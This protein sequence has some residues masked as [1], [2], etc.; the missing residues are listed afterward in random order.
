MV[1]GN[2]SPV[3]ARYFC[4]MVTAQP[5]QQRLLSNA[6]QAA[7]SNHYSGALCRMRVKKRQITTTAAPSDECKLSV[8][9]AFRQ[10]DRQTIGRC[11]A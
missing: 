7:A 2:K 9:V 6:S 3:L 4:T 1:Q 8:D 11:H 5:L 10:R